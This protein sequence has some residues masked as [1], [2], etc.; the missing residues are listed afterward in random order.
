MPKP[1]IGDIA[2]DVPLTTVSNEV[3]QLSS[4]WQSGN[5]TLLIFLRHLA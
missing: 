1:S 4:A 2:P 5:I 3:I